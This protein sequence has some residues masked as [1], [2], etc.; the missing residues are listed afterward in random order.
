MRFAILLMI[1]SSCA[2]SQPQSD[3]TN[4]VS[5]DSIGAFCNDG[6][7]PIQCYPSVFGQGDSYCESA[8]QTA[9]YG[10]GYCRDY[11]AAD[12]TYCYQ[13]CV[14]STT[15][16]TYTATDPNRCAGAVGGCVPIFPTACLAGER[17]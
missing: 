17:P 11:T 8:C 12:V 2:V 7:G 3:S 4:T 15:F 10:T 14:W 9:G 5:Q 6:L 16:N 13:H 1:V